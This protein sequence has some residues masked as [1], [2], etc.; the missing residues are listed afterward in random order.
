M[1]T[2]TINGEAIP[3]REAAKLVKMICD[4]A[5]QVA[6]EFHNMERSDKFRVNWPSET[7]FAESEWKG[8]VVA[9]REMYAA[10]LADPLTTPED[11]RTMHL[12]LVLERMVSQ[13]QEQDNRLQ[14]KPNTQQFVGDPFENRKIKKQFGTAPN[15][16]AALA[17]STA[18]I[19][20][21]I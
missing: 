9:V 17:N 18:A 10:R 15:L 16:R 5:K 2:I 11:A 20:R 1:K 19:L 14:L 3:V 8:F 21:N 4:D 7:L 12:A 13:G 6:G